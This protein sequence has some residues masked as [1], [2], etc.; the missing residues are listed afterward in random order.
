[1][2][3]AHEALGHLFQLADTA[4]HFLAKGA[5]SPENLQP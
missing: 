2:D 3:V 5:L 1:M 4:Q